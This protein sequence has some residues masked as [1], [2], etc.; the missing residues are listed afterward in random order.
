MP[1]HGWQLAGAALSYWTSSGITTPAL[2][3][4]GLPAGASAV[5]LAPAA[6]LARRPRQWQPSQQSG[7]SSGGFLFLPVSSTHAHGRSLSFFLAV[8]GAE[9][10]LGPEGACPLELLGDA[11]VPGGR[12]VG[13][14]RP[15]QE[16]WAASASSVAGSRQEKAGSRGDTLVGRVGAQPPPQAGADPS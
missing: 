16:R 10:S 13:A 15:E 14:T 5:G 1:V 12:R 8:G 2:R 7:A 9:A 11:L 3:G 4:V 6:K